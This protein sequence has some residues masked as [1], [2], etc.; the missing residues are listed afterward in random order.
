[1]EQHGTVQFLGLTQQ[2]SQVLNIVAIHRPQIGKTHL[3]E[4]IAADEGFFHKLFDAVN[5]G[6]QIFATGGFL[7]QGM[8]PPLKPQIGGLQ[9]LGSKEFCHTAHIGPNGHAVVIEH[10]NN[11]FFT[12][13][14]IVKA[15]ISKT[16]GQ[17]AVTD[18]SNDAVIL[19]R[20]GSGP[21]HTQRRGY[22]IGGM[23]SHKGIRLRLI[24]SRKACH[25]AV[26]PQGCKT[27]HAACQQLMDIGLMPH[28]K[29]DPI[30]IGIKDLVQGYGKLDSTQIGGQMTAGFGYA[31][32]QKCSNF[33][34][35]SG[36]FLRSE[37]EKILSVAC[38]L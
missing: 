5:K 8:E 27:L 10:H 31:V 6:V 37:P 12:L 16:A 14:G 7:R 26:L 33:A 13:S 18:D 21:C 29:D 30:H 38:S 1:M 15:L 25:T 11:G 3:I 32:Q 2:E 36:I 28:I 34:A 9:P 17:S 19:T 35:K 22:G 4:H 20:Q 24:G 23:A